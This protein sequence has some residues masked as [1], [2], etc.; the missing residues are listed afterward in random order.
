MNA[1]FAL[2]M[3]RREARASHRRLLLYGSC[4]ALG[5]AALVGLHGV[6]ATVTRAVNAQARELLGADLRLSSRAPLS[7]ELESRLA[8]LATRAETRTARVTQFASM[9]LVPRTGLTRLADVRGVDTAFPFY[10]AVETQPAR[11]WGVLA[12]D[13]RAALVDA[14]L[15]L[16]LDARVGDALRIGDVEFRIVGSVGRAPGSIGLRT[17]IAP[18]IFISRASV[19]ATHLL[20]PGSLVDHIAYLAAPEPQ[21][22]AW[23]ARHRSSF[24]AQRVRVQTVSSYQADLGRA[25][26]SLTR[27]L[28]LVG[29]AALALGGVGVAAGVRV[30]VREKL[31]AVAVLRSLGASSGDVLAA[32]GLLA[33]L[34]GLAAGVAGAAFGVA[35]QWSLPVLLRGLLPV[36]VAGRVEPAAVATGLGLGLWVTALFTLGPIFEL[37]RVPPL[38]ALRRDF[39][40]EPGPRR[41]AA[42]RA[43]LLAASLLGV[44][45]WQAPSPG[46]GLAF[47]AGLGAALALLALAAHGAAALLRRQ[48]LPGAP[49]WLRQ[50]IANLF[51]PRNHTLATTVAIG[52]GLF[53]VAT[54]H[55]VQHNVRQQMAIDARPDRPNLVIFDVQPDQVK[56]LEKLLAARQT[57]ILDRAPIVSARIARIDGREVSDWLRESALDREL[58]WAL[59]REYRLSYAS[60]LRATETLIE[61]AW[62]PTAEPEPGAPAP[63]SLEREIAETL[64]AEIGTALTWDVQGVRVESRVAS[65][66]NVDWKR[67]APNFF[68]VFPP[69]ALADAPQSSFLLVRQADADARARLQREVVAA[70]PNVSLIDASVVLAAVD[71][72]H[73]EMGRAVQVLSLFT[74][75]TGFVILIAAAAAARSERR[76]E[77]LLLRT[78]GA[79]SRLVRRIVASEA[80]A[81]GALAAGVGAGLALIASWALVVFVF[82]LPF[83]P[84]LGDLALLAFATLA[85]CAL[86][87]AGGGR[88]SRRRSPF[89]ALRDAE[90]TG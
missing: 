54:L 67:V 49:Y 35:V 19:D 27:Y 85:L 28:G 44:S 74:L 8:Q 4:M 38:R 62:W 6:R 81:L 40:S 13:P 42:G 2:A 88:A 80:V 56:P 21:L 60:K 36:D 51:R 65:V 52:F 73:R 58:R 34:L 15:L 78:L 25:F 37:S 79:S 83:S 55:A 9:A 31:D 5:I 18:R 53:L 43:L 41:G 86:L 87:G 17:Q 66:R 63:V 71:A 61:G 57:P 64:G 75:A 20:R 82:E 26:T 16:Q 76:R 47:A 89:A 23:L 7:A 33:L 11:L 68:A 1:R 29:L 48:R 30:F 22:E 84:P 14:S 32:Y 24:E 72:M 10:G 12:S 70:F 46:V 90:L 39:E 45:L 50:G 59:R 69:A 3:A 77:A